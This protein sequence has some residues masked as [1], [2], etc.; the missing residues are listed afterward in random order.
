MHHLILCL[1][2][3]NFFLSSSSSLL[4]KKFFTSKKKHFWWIKFPIWFTCWMNFILNDIFFFFF[5]LFNIQCLSKSLSKDFFHR[6]RQTLEEDFLLK[7]KKKKIF[8]R[9]Y[10]KLSLL[11]HLILLEKIFHHQKKRI[12]NKHNEITH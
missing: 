6:E 5:L 4:H 1:F 7:R 3:E 8:G 12:N 11:F 9:E 2:E 10:E